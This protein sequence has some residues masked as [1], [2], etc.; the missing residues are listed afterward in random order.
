MDAHPL[1]TTAARRGLGDGTSLEASPRLMNYLDTVLT[2]GLMLQAEL[3]TEKDLTSLLDTACAVV[4][5]LFPFSRMGFAW[6]DDAGLDCCLR[7]CRP[8]TAREAM[9]ADMERLIAEGF[10][11]WAMSQNRPMAAQLRSSESMALLCPMSG[12]GRDYGLFIGVGNAAPV[13]DILLKVLS[14]VLMHCMHAVESMELRNALQDHS[15]NL[16]ELVA[17]RTR[18]LREVNQ[19]LEAAVFEARQLAE[20]AESAN[21]AKSAF[22]ANMSHEIRT[23][24]NGIIGMTGLLLDTALDPNQY[25]YAETVRICSEALLVLINDILD[26]TKIEA[27]RLD[28]EML[29]FDLLSLLDD[30]MASLA[31]KAHEKGLELAYSV[32]SAVPTRLR[33]DPGRLRQ[34]LTNLVGNAVKFTQRGEVVLQ[35]LLEAE[36]DDAALLRFIVR[37]TGIGIPKE[38]IGMLFSKF[39]QVDSSTTRKYGGTGLGLAISK[40]L[41]EMMGGEVGVESESGKG[42]TFW[43]T[44]RIKKQP[45]AQHDAAPAPPTDLHQVRALIVDNNAANRDI[46]SARLAEWGMRAETTEDG[47]SALDALRC[48]AQGGDPFRIAIIDMQMPGMDGEAVGRAIQADPRLAKTHMVMLTSLGARGVARRFAE[49]GFA[50]YLTK[51][52]RHHELK[53]VLALAL[54]PAEQSKEPAPIVTRHTAREIPGMF[55][56]R[57]NRVLLA[58][59]NIINQ[60]V[61]LGI[62]K[63]LGTAAEAV[64]NGAEAIKALERIPYDLVFMDCQM[65]DMDGYAAT[66]AIRAGEFPVLNPHIPIIAMTAHTMQGDREKCLEAGMDDYISKPVDPLLLAEILDKWLPAKEERQ[67]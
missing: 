12:H 30:L 32:Y 4:E 27:G 39:S 47:A 25:K 15:R 14:M 64:S 43:F 16:E 48:A 58:E 49:M 44:A 52:V 56:E 38:K 59:D 8:E 9:T 42:S 22:L 61:A 63:K 24:M 53:V 31:I 45:V 57:P 10:M 55:R 20:R 54:T 21:N 28:F 50:A 40:Q 1:F 60:Q 6:F 62:L 29:D 36:T 46:L 37:D 5:R 67:H 2:A 7:H 35:V 26:F 18:D 33:G 51:P 17:Q 11:G 66:R 65:P 3:R 41:A 34:I 19:R 23:P 13:P